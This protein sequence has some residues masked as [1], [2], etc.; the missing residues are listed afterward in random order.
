MDVGSLPETSFT[1]L[2][3]PP[4]PILSIL[5]PNPELNWNKAQQLQLIKVSLTNIPPRLGGVNF[6]SYGI[7]NNNKSHKG[8]STSS[9]SLMAHQQDKTGLWKRA[10]VSDILTFALYP[11]SLLSS[12][13]FLMQWVCYLESSCVWLGHMPSLAKVSLYII[14]YTEGFC[15]G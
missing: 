7:G 9:E 12:T 13:F 10:I 8:W 3:Q 5:T 11:K 14:C 15:F 2:M 1:G 4:N 6:L